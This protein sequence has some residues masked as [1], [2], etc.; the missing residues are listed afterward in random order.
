MN[1]PLG[2]LNCAILTGGNGT[3]NYYELS[4]EKAVEF[5]KDSLKDGR[6]IISAV[7]HKATSDILTTL[8]ETEIPCNRIQFKQ[9]VGQGCIVF[10]LNKRI[11][12]GRILSREEIEEI[13]YKF[14]Y[15]LM[16]VA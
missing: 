6:G 2:I 4:R 11:E 5:V 8:L 9:E 16:S 3:Y 12:E 7:G 15:L 13:G 1:K 10:S 14:F